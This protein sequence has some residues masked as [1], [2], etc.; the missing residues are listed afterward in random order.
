[1]HL[2]IPNCS[3]LLETD[4]PKSGRGATFDKE[5]TGGHFALDES[6][7]H[8]KVLLLE[9]VFFGFKRLCSYLGQTHIKVLSDNTIAVCDINNIGICKSLLCDQEVR[10]IWSWAIGRDIFI[11][12]AHIPGIL[13][14]EADQKSRKS[15][16]RTE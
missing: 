1:M 14:V 13:K 7:L 10:R 9:T 11:T 15:E 4:A 16:L 3:F 8:I 12:A 6:L 5:I 2:Q